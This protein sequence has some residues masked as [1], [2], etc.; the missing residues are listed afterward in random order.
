MFLDQVW[1]GFLLL[2][3]IVASLS[4]ILGPPIFAV[5]WWGNPRRRDRWQMAWAAWA[6]AI[7]PL[8]ITLPMAAMLGEWVRDVRPF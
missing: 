2:G 3:V 6:M 7:L 8:P 1:W 5:W 4:L